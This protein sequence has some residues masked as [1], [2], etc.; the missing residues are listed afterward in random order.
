MKRIFYYLLASAVLTATAIS[1]NK[2]KVQDED[3]LPAQDEF[4]FTATTGEL[5][6]TTVED[7]E[8]NE[9]IVKWAVGDEISV[10]WDGGSTTATAASADVTTTFTPAATPGEA[11]FYYAAY[12]S[13][14]AS[15]FADET[16]TVTV[17]ASQTGAFA[18]ANIAVAK[19]TDADLDFQFANIT[20]LVKFSVSGASYTKAVFRGGKGET[21]AGTVP[22]DMSGAP[23]LGEVTSPAKEIEVTLSGAGDYYISVLPCTLEGGFSVSLYEGENT[24]PAAYLPVEVALA[25]GT[26]T[27]LGAIDNKSISN[28]FVTPAGAGKKNGKNWENALGTAELRGLIKQVEGAAEYQ[29]SVLDG[30]TFHMAK[31]DYYLAEGETSK[32]VKVEFN[33]YSKQVAL[34]FKGGY[35]DNLTGTNTSGW[36]I[37][38][39]EATAPT[40]CTAFTG[41]EEAGIFVFGNQTN[42]TF[43]GI[44]FKDAKFD[45]SKDD[46][47]LNCAAG[48]T[49]N[50]SINLDY[51]RILDNKNTTAKSGAGIIAYKAALSLSHCYFKGNYA[52]N[53]GALY[54][55]NGNE[56]AKTFSYCTFENNS[57]SN[58]SGAIQNGGQTNVTFDHCAFTSNS[59]PTY[60][61]AFHTG[62]SANT[63][64]EDCTFTSNSCTGQGGAISLESSSSATFTRCTFTANTAN[65]GD[66]SRSGNGELTSSTGTALDDNVAGGAIFNRGSGTLTINA[67]T[68]ENNTAP[69]GC[70]GSIG[71]TGASSTLKINA[72][73][74]FSGNTAFFHGGAIFAMGNFTITG[75]SDSK[76]TFTNCKTLDASGTGYGQTANGGAIWLA[77]SKT[78]SISYAKFD[79]CEAGQEDD[80]TVEYSNGGA[81]SIK[82]VT[83][84]TASN[85]EFTACR[86]RNGGALNIEPGTSSTITFTD[87]SFHDNIGRSGESKNG[88][89][90]NFHGAV[91]R[92][93]GTGKATFNTCT[94]TDN[95]IYQSGAVFHMNSAATVECNDCTFTNNDAMTSSGGSFCQENGTYTFNRC[96][97]TGGDA[98]ASAGGM[99]YMVKGTLNLNDTEVS[100]CKSAATKQGG[101][102]YVY[103]GGTNGG[104]VKINA[105]RSTFKNNQVGTAASGDNYGAAIRAEGASGKVI[106]IDVADCVFSGNKAYRFGIVISLKQYGILKA[107][108]CIFT[109]N[110]GGSRAVIN[111]EGNS[112]IFLN[113]CAFYNNKMSENSAWGMSVHGGASTAAACINNCTFYNNSFTQGS[114]NDSCVEINGDT[115]IL[116]INSTVISNSPYLIRANGQSVRLCNNILVNTRAASK[117]IHSATSSTTSNGHN[118]MSGSC[119]A[120]DATDLTNCTASSFT[121]GAWELNT[122]TS[123]Y[124]GVYSWTG[125]LAGFTAATSSDV[126]GAI[127]AYTQTCAALGSTNAGAYFKT[128]LN[129][130]KDYTYDGRGIARTG[131]WWPGAYQQN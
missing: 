95:K 107:N 113:S 23:A 48:T 76:V 52:R 33:G 63:T 93:G 73:T 32:R 65:K 50:C 66:Q 11:D 9:K 21:L 38:T 56:G 31:G 77:N 17:P 78:Y 57:A 127:D 129:S 87:C 105:K 64:F 40:N 104:T 116:I 22:V 28:Y 53:A 118:A 15:A 82:S 114:P 46:G 16:L 79:G 128:W 103:T 10:Y 98:L 5:T 12:P 68:F 121:S 100:S 75:T 34:T 27:T 4:V 47:A 37:P 43:Q 88:S 108:R 120:D 61:G 41:N 119:G 8:G 72:G 44:T 58:T 49:G 101:A 42:I 13:G 1:C 97:I 59:C 14:V 55:P 85:C 131:T 109:D 111:Y 45:G 130:T 92:F 123:P 112:A 39:A 67:C 94:F 122:T 115:P 80:S 124:Y 20:A 86:G 29:A 126:E 35:P 81:I 90:G 26:I 54:L 60:G 83:S 110:T 102:I 91:A 24:A 74:S 106:T 51:C 62:S 99:I 89:A 18:A 6:K 125:P 3:V 71:I 7:G 36:T 30:V 69:N 96:K 2:E 25:R 84:F 70:G 117:I 19:T